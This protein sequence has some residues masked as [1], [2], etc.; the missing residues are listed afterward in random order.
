MDGYVQN[1]AREKSKT[2]FSRM[3]IWNN[4]FGVFTVS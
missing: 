1:Y 3:E 4:N 2:A